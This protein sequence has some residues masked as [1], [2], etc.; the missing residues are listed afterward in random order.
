[1]E[2]RFCPA[3]GSEDLRLVVSADGTVE[4]T[5]FSCEACGWAGL[6]GQLVIYQGEPDEADAPT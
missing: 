3:C 6:G 2:H 4:K 1:M 5:A